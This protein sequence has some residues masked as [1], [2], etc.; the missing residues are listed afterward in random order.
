MRIK[1]LLL[2]GCVAL[3]AGFWLQCGGSGNSGSSTTFSSIVP[4]DVVVT[5]PTANLIVVGNG[6][7]LSATKDT[8]TPTYEA[9]REDVA[10]LAG[11]T[12]ECT[13]TAE[14]FQSLTFANCYGPS[15]IYDNHPTNVPANSTY[16]GGDLGIWNSTNMTTATEACSAAQMNNVVDFAASRVDTFMNILAAISCAATKGGTALPAVGASVALTSE[17]TSYVTVSGLSITTATLERLADDGSNPVY[18]FTINGTYTM[19]SK[20]YAVTFV[21]K[22][23]P[24]ATDGST[25]KGKFAFSYGLTDPTNPKPLNCAAIAAAAEGSVQ[26]GTIMY[27]KT[28]ATNI[29]YEMNF[30][31]FCGATTNPFD[32]NLNISASD[33]ASTTNPDGWANNYNYGLFSINPTTGM[34]SVAYAWQAGLGDAA[35]RTLNLAV[36][37]NA[38][39]SASGD[40]YF[41]FGPGM[42]TS[43][44]T[45]RGTIERMYCNW[46]GT[47]VE[48]KAQHQGLTRLSDS[49]VF[50][51]EAGDEHITFSPT[52]TCDYAGGA[53]VYSSDLTLKADPMTNDNV[54]G[55]AV[56]NNLVDISTMSFTRPTPPTDVGG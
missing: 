43:T 17:I 26:A 55:L 30:A 44:S 52:N 38:D 12:A 29:V 56:T 8:I 36:T 23:I 1:G 7:A 25:Y 11:G 34:G 10:T 3:A 50:S 22:H 28:A 24:T 42:P 14:A 39:G 21:M 37:A 48:S 33:T 20:A 31:E 5:S 13:F 40:A 18:R 53:F 2:L 6:A 4:V 45:T 27:E 54:L 47:P 41:G 51:V 46:G 19:D 49:A 15:V 16:G 9:K 35:A 32:A